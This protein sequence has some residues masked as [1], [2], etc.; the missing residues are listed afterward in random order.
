MAYLDKNGLNY[1]SQ[2]VSG[3]IQDVKNDLD[4]LKIIEKEESEVIDI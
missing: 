3:K 1:Y 2:K 4:E